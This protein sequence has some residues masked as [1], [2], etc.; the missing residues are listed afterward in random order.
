M[1]DHKLVFPHGAVRRTQ[2]RGTRNSPHETLGLNDIL[3]DTPEYP[4]QYALFTAYHMDEQYLLRHI[5]P[6]AEVALIAQ[7]TTNKTVRHVTRL[8]P[9]LPKPEVQ[10]I[11]TKLMLLYYASSMRFVVLTGN[12]VPNDWTVVQN[13][14]FVQDFRRSHKVFP[15]NEFSTT[16]AYALHDLGV[17]KGFI[18]M[19]NNVDFSLAV[20][21]IVTSVPSSGDKYLGQRNMDEY[22]VERLAS[23][24]KS[25]GVDK[26][27]HGINARNIDGFAP[28]ARLYCTG[29]SLGPM[30]DK[31]LCDMYL[32][33]HGINHSR[34]AHPVNPLVLPWNMVDIGVAFPTQRQVDQSLFNVAK[35]TVYLKP[36]YYYNREFPK[37]SLVC[38]RPRVART[39]VH[40]KVILASFGERQRD[41]WMYLGSHNFTPAAWGRMRVGGKIHRETYFNNYE[42]GV[43]LDSIE[44]RSMGNDQMEID[45]FWNG[46]KVGLPFR[47]VWEP[48]SRD[49]VPYLNG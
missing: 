38:L 6:T 18:A 36:Q 49:D 31:W 27:N 2:M 34:C 28:N 23:I 4:I 40:A 1:P 39:L 19:M 44:F 10:I 37:T 41:G 47:Y 26:Q 21:R 30:D 29:S 13:S 7:H 9:E 8:L 15:A 3:A 25:L 20:A 35:E 42:L 14:V 33:A 24:V 5:N 16:L 22:G 45:V 32:A 46:R 43:V 12:F 17:P 48:Y 11:H